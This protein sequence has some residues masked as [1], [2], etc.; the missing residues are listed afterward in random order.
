MQRL[1]S[2]IIP[3]HNGAAFID[4]CL[5]AAFAS[6]H[7]NFEVVVVDD[8]STDNSLELINKYPCTV[9][10]IVS[11]SGASMARN[12]GARASRGDILFFIDADCVLEP[13]ALERAEAAAEK[14]GDSTVIGGTYT[15]RPHDPG[16]FSTFQSAFIHYSETKNRLSPD[17]I[18]SHALIINAEAFRQSGGF[19]EKF[20]PIIEDVEFSHRLKA[21]KYHLVMEPEILVR[22]IFNFSLVTSL[23]NAFRKSRYWTRYSLHNRD[24]LADSGT[25]SRELKG[26]VVAWAI[27][28]F[29]L[30]IGHL[31]QN[32][33]LLLPIPVLMA[34]N[35]S[36]NRGQ[37]GAFY[38]AGGA[39]FS[40]GAGLYYFLV[41]PLPVAAG[42]TVGIVEYLRE[43]IS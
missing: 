1:I 12:A 18:A 32:T 4:T 36:L 25:A 30:G 31:L 42:A 33:G 13:D 37:L 35:I 27:I 38:Q 15:L 41:Y 16:F 22:H 19:P 7:S 39:L 43:G 29:L 3:C 11:R 23:K 17:Y 2:L 5:A 6:R 34:W 9:V 14:Y 8:G 40:M 21:Q 10:P 24:V 28:G 26:N 20:M